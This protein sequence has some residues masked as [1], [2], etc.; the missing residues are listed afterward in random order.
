MNFKTLTRQNTGSHMLDSG[1][2]YGYQYQR[3]IQKDI[4]LSIDTG[5]HRYVSASIPLHLFLGNSLTINN[6]LTN[7]LRREEK[8]QKRS[9]TIPEAGQF[10][11]KVTKIKYLDNTYDNSYNQENDLDQ[12][13]QSAVLSNK[14]DWFYDEDALVLIETHNGCDI[15]GGYSDVVVCK[16]VSDFG[17]LLD[18]VV[19]WNVSKIVSGLENTR[20]NQQGIDENWQ[21]GYS[22]YPTS[23]FNNDIKR[24]LAINR[25]TNQVRVELKDGV[26]VEVYPNMRDY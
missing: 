13:Y 9:F 24:I 3:P 25:K 23:K 5:K 4:E 22:S 2:I 26:V 21:I 8:K 10:L 14:N 11:E 20:E 19:G 1:S 6:R 16:L 18:P 7:L 15:R 17:P 12:N